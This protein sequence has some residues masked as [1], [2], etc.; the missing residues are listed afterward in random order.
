MSVEQQEQ[1]PLIAAVEAA[2]RRLVANQALRE[3]TLAA[4]IALLGPTLLLFFGR[5]LFTWPLLIVFL[6]GGVAVGVWRLWR[7]RPSL[8]QVSQ[9]L[10][11][12][13]VLQDQVSTAIHFLPLNEPVALEQRRAAARLA[14]RSQVEAAFPFTMPRAIYGLASV[15]LLASTLW[16]IRYFLEK[17]FRLA[18]PLPQVIARA[19]G[20]VGSPDGKQQQESIQEAR[21]SPEK[22]A[23]AL[24]LE[25]QNPDQRSSGQKGQDASQPATSGSTDPDDK[26][27]A[28]A[29]R[30]QSEG[31]LASD[32]FGDPMSSSAENDAIQS[33]EDMLVRDAKSGLAKAE[34]KQGKDGDSNG[35]QKDGRPDAQDSPN[36]LL[37]KLREAMNNMLS[38]LQQKSPGMGKQ[39][40]AAGGQSNGGEQQEGRGEGRSGSGQ[41]QPGGQEATDGEGSEADAKDASGQS[42]AGKSGGKS[43]DGGSRG[44]TGDGAGQQEGDKQILEAQQQAALGKLSELYGRRAASVTGE[45]TVEAQSGKQTLRTPQSQKQARHSDTG[46]EVSRDEIPLAYQ[47]YVKEY[48]NKLRQADKKP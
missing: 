44:S 37:A 21:R 15:F 40:Q 25:H 35:N 34:G 26:R 1:R 8:Y 41:P 45:V 36:S 29:A 20:G 19:I 39:Q 31:L 10:D 32:E 23:E 2:Q 4:T 13:L 47:A 30:D 33:Y 43:A 11:A 14:N 17:P 38:R 6:L 12:R 42:A 9:V 18:Q 5:D 16:A 27:K 46:G 24:G 28:E 22:Q 48:F 3:S 7:R